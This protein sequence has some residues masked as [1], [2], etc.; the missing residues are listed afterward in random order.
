MPLPST[1]LPLHSPPPPPPPPHWINR[2]SQQP[3]RCPPRSHRLISAQHRASY[4]RSLCTQSNL[5]PTAEIFIFDFR[6]S[7]SFGQLC[8]C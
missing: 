1:L 7:L 3:N 4:W 5:D 2:A 6:S 8:L